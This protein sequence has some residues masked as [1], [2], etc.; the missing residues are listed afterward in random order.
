M[1]QT[2]H[3]ITLFVLLA[4]FAA[5]AQPEGSRWGF[6]FRPA[7]S[8]ATARFGGSALDPGLGFEGTFSYR[9]MPHLHAYAGWGW[10]RMS[11]GHSFAGS[12]M[13]FEETGYTFGLQFVH[14]LGETGVEY[15]FRAG[16]VYD[17]IETENADGDIVNDSKHGFGWQAEA[18][19]SVTVTESLSLQPTL[20]FRSLN[21]TVT[22]GGTATDVGLRALTVGAGLR[23][24]L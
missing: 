3:A 12:D 23:W 8:V 19:V 13:D 18:G 17:H 6:E 21:R 10:H 4:P 20:R 14:P 15:L 22:I 9:M 16:A 7:L 24:A 11:A 1:K 5:T 2:F